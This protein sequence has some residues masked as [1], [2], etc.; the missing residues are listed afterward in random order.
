[1]VLARLPSSEGLG[2]GGLTDGTCRW[3]NILF[4]L[5]FGLVC[6]LGHRT[7]DPKSGFHR[8]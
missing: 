3:A 5:L 4:S 2:G 8:H 7:A 6:L 1:L